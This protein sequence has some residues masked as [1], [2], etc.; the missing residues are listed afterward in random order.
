MADIAIA[1]LR[2]LQSI[3]QATSLPVFLDVVEWGVRLQPN[4]GLPADTADMNE[5]V[6][7]CTD[8]ETF[9]SQAEATARAAAPETQ[10]A[11]PEAA[12]PPLSR[13]RARMSRG[14]SRKPRPKPRWR[15]EPGTRSRLARSGQRP[16]TVVC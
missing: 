2:R 5:L 16:R 12:S 4:F 9:L 14:A 7:N 13:Q 15:Q 3:M 8:I 1:D 10:S 11:L 6:A